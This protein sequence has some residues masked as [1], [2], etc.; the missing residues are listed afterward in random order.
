MSKIN[1]NVVKD[2]IKKLDKVSDD[3]W[4]DIIRRY[5]LDLNPH[6]LRKRSYGM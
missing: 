3:T 4:E 1:K 6:E 2:C 5:D